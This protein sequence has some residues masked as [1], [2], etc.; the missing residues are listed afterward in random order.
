M[1]SELSGRPSIGL[2]TGHFGWRAAPPYTHF[3]EL[4]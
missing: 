2:P 1:A 4:S 3:I